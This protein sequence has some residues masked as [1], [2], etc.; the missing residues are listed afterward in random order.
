MRRQ[1]QTGEVRFLGFAID[2]SI[3]RPQRIAL[4]PLV[5]MGEDEHGRDLLQI[6]GLEEDPAAGGEIGDNGR[7][8]KIV[9]RFRV[10]RA[11]D[12]RVVVI[13]KRCLVPR[14]CVLG[15]AFGNFAIAAPHGEKH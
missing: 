2:R 8:E 6:F 5:F 9:S 12:I 14:L 15:V 1:F 10:T 11:L 7:P 3:R 13:R 4:K